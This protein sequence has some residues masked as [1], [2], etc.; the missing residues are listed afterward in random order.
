MGGRAVALQIG[1]FAFEVAGTGQV[2]RC[3][4]RSV[5]LG[6]HSSADVVIA[7]PHVSRLH[8]RV[9]VEDDAYVLRDLGSRNGTR[10]GGARIRAAELA[11]G[12]TFELGATQLRFR[13]GDGA[14][15]IPLA[16]ADAFEGLVGRS[17]AMREVFATCELAARSDA[18]VLVEGETGTGKDLVAQAIHARSQR[19]AGPLVVFDCAAVPPQLFESE[20]FGHEKGAFTGAVT[21]RVGLLERA[22][23]GTLFLDELG[24]LAPELQPKLLRCLES[25]E[26]RRVGGDRTIAVDVRLVAATHCDLPRMIADNRFRADLYYRL[27]VVR[28]RVPPLRERREDIPLLAAHFAREASPSAIPDDTLE[29]LFGELTARDWPGN[30]RELRNLVERAVVLAEPELLRAPEPERAAGEMQRSLDLAAHK[31]HSLRA[32]RAE[33]ERT[34][35]ADL[36]R[37]TN[38]QLDEAAR[39]AQVHRK[40][41]ERLLRRYKLRGGA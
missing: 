30:V 1:G 12:T 2:H 36:L 14:F 22:H 6:S 9:D 28:L 38:H 13:L 18:P 5:L 29:A 24:E 32:V 41:L 11:D 25:G 33:L 31:R 15:E 3:D 23:G 40:S 34:Y 35:L 16:D 26:L 19:R 27:A 20:L 10:I 7:A 37:T 21:A 39:I 17:V 4:R 8:A